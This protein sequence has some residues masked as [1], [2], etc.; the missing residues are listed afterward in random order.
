MVQENPQA[1][2][3]MEVTD[4]ERAVGSIQPDQSN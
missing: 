4:D 1:G 3:V 2:T